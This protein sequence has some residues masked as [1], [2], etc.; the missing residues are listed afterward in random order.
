LVSERIT[1]KWKILRRSGEGEKGW[2]LPWSKQEEGA[3]IFWMKRSACG[4]YSLECSRLWVQTAVRSNQRLWNWYF[5]SA[6]HVAPRSIAKT[7]W[8]GIN[9]VSWVEPYYMSTHMHG[10]L[11]QCASTLKK[12]NEW[13]SCLTLSE[14]I[15]CYIIISSPCQRQ[16]ELLPSLGIRR[17]SFV[18]FSY[19]NLLLWN[20]S[21]IWTET[22]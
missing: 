8:L 2:C 22:R 3:Y 4:S 13:M 12:K 18:N 10:L 15:F 19:F 17:L 16:C 5:F 20:P 6:K 1:N 9:N 7:G 11:F 21:A 14:N